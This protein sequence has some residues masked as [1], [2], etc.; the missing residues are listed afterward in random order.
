MGDYEKWLNCPY[1]YNHRM[2]SGRFQ[3]HLVKCPDKKR[4]GH[5][6]DPCPF[7][8]QHIILK[9]EM[10][11]H[12]SKCPDGRTSED[13]KGESDEIDRQIREYLAN[14]HHV[15]WSNAEQDEWT[16]A[17][18]TIVGEKIE[19]KSSDLNTK[20]KNQKRNAARRQKKNEEDPNNRSDNKNELSIEE[21][22]ADNWEQLTTEKSNTQP[23]RVPTIP[24]THQGT[25]PPY[26]P[27]M[28]LTA[29]KKNQ[30]E[31][32]FK[33]VTKKKTSVVQQ[34]QPY[35]PLLNTTKDKQDVLVKMESNGS[36]VS[37]Q[38]SEKQ[39]GKKNEI[40]EETKEQAKQR[41]LKNCN[42]LLKQIEELDKKEKEGTELN[43]DQR[44]KKNR[45]GELE[46]EIRN[47]SIVD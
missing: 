47:L 41:K 27:P 12:K 10:A 18:R 37:K 46:E 4:V 29:F 31:E 16:P 32:E 25:P 13:H 20:N 45:R 19:E 43:D 33:T 24:Q 40:Q 17:P 21:R 5:L 39:N 1:N 42:K 11:H 26:S 6:F 30:E 9:S 28:D 8:A 34:T 2:P 15:P 36:S 44:Q 38:K 22:T 14:Q 7:N 23:I 3:W 35:S